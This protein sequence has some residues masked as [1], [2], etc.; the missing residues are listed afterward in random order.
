MLAFTQFGF[1]VKALL[2]DGT[3]SNLSLYSS[4]AD[5]TKDF[6]VNGVNFGWET[7]VNVYE[8]DLYRAQHGISRRVVR[9]SWTRLNVLPAKIMDV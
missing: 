1:G 8:S 9:D 4:R 5:G 2:S 6:R 3:N 7:I